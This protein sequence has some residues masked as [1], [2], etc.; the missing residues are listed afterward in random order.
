MG[1]TVSVNLTK[2]DWQEDDAFW[3]TEWR[4]F[5]YLKMG[6]PLEHLG[7]IHRLSPKQSLD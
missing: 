2:E 7:D 1:N 3:C 5:N 6:F 4:A